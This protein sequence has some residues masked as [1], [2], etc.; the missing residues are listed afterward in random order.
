MG[1][2]FDYSEREKMLQKYLECLPSFY[3]NRK[4]KVLF[5]LRK[6]SPI[7]RRTVLTDS[8]IVCVV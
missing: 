2:L 1:L 8:N 5:V 7:K 4:T 3:Q 6:S